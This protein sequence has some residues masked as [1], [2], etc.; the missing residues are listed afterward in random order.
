MSRH[1]V[2]HKDYRICYGWDPVQPMRT[3]FMQVMSEDKNQS[4]D[5]IVDVGQG[6]IY[7][8]AFT[9]IDKFVAE[10]SRKLTEVGIIDFELSQEQ[11]F[12]L[13]NDMFGIGN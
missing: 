9:D 11:K 2:Q 10:C 8:D 13:L 6:L 5:P 4:E 1:C 7:N 12:Q 3:F